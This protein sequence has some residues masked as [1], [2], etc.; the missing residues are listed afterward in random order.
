MAEYNNGIETIALC[1]AGGTGKGTLLK[2][3]VGEN[4]YFNIIASPVQ[5]IGK[6]LAPFSKNYNDM[7]FPSKIVFQY[8]G[9]MSQISMERNAK[10][11]YLDTIVERSVFDYLAYMNEALGTKYGTDTARMEVEYSKYENIVKEYIKQERPYTKVVFVPIEF[12][13][14]D[15]K[16]SIWK[17]RNAEKRQNTERRLIS[18]LDKFKNYIDIVKVS[19]T[20]S[21][22][23]KQIQSTLEPCI[24]Y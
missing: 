1:G 11:N 7:D 6:K 12:T 20:T 17:E 23:V 14:K 13:P 4:P 19:G 15:N 3:F 22:R 2:A 10:D 8:S 16:K 18:I 21:K 9:L 24:R 5:Y